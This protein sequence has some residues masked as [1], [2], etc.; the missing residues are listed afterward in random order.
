MN[1]VLKF[2]SVFGLVLGA[3]PGAGASPFPAFADEIVAEA[4]EL[5]V[6]QL[7]RVQRDIDQKRRT[8]RYLHESGLMVEEISQTAF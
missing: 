6:E 5:S 7:G 3:A 8:T 1:S 4:A 2:L